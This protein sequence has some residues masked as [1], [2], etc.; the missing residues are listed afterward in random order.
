M[1]RVALAVTA[2]P[3]A[4]CRYGCAGCCAAPIA[5]FWIAGIVSLIY[6]YY[7]GPLNVAGIS[8]Y[9]MG[10]G[11]VLWAIAGVWA[12]LTV[13]LVDEDK[14]RKKSSP[15]CGRIAPGAD[16][17]DPMDEVRKAKAR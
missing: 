4:V 17:H 12:T 8:W 16:E 6:G 7:G 2:P 14:C 13:R 5:V 9:T 15:L 3:L 10:L 1:N 11:V